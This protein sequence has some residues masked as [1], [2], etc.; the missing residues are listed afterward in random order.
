MPTDEAAK[1]DDAHLEK[2]SAVR[3]K[4]FLGEPD[5]GGALHVSRHTFTGIGGERLTCLG[6]ALLEFALGEV[7][8]Q[9]AFYVFDKLVE[10]MLLGASSII[11]H[12]RLVVDGASMLLRRGTPLQM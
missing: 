8:L 4:V 12:G 3:H 10:P 7:W 5:P 6:R 11:E 1:Q 2:S 9:T